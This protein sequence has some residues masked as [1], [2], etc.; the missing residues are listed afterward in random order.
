MVLTFVKEKQLY[1]QEM[2]LMD[3]LNELRKRLIIVA[4]ALIVFFVLGF[5][6]VQDIYRWMVQDLGVKLTILGPTDI[7][8]VYFM[9]AGVFAITLTI[10]VFAWQTWLFVK[11][12]LTPKERKVTL[13]YIPATFILF[14][15]GLCFGYFVV[16]PIVFHFL[17]GLGNDMF[18]TMFTT[19]KYFRFVLHM[20]LPFAVLF[21]LPVIVMFLTRIGL[22]NPYALQKVRKYAYFV[23]VVVAVSITP[24]DFISDFLVTIPLL[25]LYEIS[26]SI[27]KFV[28][29]KRENSM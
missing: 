11:P 19:E 17:I 6:F 8:W 13:S 21:E 5:V 15:L 7:L 3:H 25:L 26:I 28:Y 29:K 24:P 27:S 22:I 20:T 10:P 18:A 4:V 2:P 23:L 1:D 12:A 9:L 16:L 14:V